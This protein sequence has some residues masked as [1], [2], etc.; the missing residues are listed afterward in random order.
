MEDYLNI[1]GR[2][3]IVY[4]GKI[5]SVKVFSGRE[6]VVIQGLC[7]S[8]AKV[9]ACDIEW[10]LGKEKVSVPV[11]MSAGPFELVTE[12]KNLPENVYSFVLYT[13]DRQ[14]NRSI[15]VDVVGQTYGEYYMA[16][17][18]NR[19]FEK[20]ILKGT[21]VVVT[22]YSLDKTLRPIHTELMYKTTTGETK[23]V[24]SPI[25]DSETLLENVDIS[26]PLT[27]RTVYQPDE[28]CLDIFETEYAEMRIS[29]N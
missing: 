1:V 11:D 25:S 3:E 29:A 20:A 6:R 9:V 5:D 18:R 24:E 4:P 16:Q 26:K 21:S 27:Y 14:G 23:I 17:I 8:D 13:R 15:P 7:I 22:W 28:T 10:N 19:P 12:I 2:D